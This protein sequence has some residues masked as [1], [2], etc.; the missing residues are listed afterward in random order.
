MGL[1]FLAAFA[2]ASDGQTDGRVSNNRRH[3]PEPF[4]LLSSNKGF[5]WRWRTE[6][7]GRARIAAAARL[8][9]K[10]ERTKGNNAGYG[11]IGVW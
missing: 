7:A 3:Q 8:Q 4:T 10:C 11:R 1:T 5:M 2:C 6:A 9:K